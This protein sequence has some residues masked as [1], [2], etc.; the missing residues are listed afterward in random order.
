MDWQSVSHGLR[1]KPFPYYVNPVEIVHFLGRP[2]L[3]WSCLEDRLVSAPGPPV[4]AL[5]SPRS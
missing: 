4:V 5:G 1:C 3:L 2:S